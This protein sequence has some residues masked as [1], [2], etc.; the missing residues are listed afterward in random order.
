MPLYPNLTCNTV[1]VCKGCLQH[2][3][4][5][6]LSRKATKDQVCELRKCSLNLEKIHSFLVLEKSF[7]FRTPV[8]GN[9]EINYQPMFFFDIRVPSYLLVLHLSLFQISGL[10]FHFLTCPFDMVGNYSEGCKRK[11]LLS[12]TVYLI[13]MHFSK[14]HFSLH[15]NA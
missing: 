5:F 7:E 11:D 12:T 13:Y 4:P 1:E 6:R 15:K 14:L 2:L 3:T 8:L 10:R 9:C